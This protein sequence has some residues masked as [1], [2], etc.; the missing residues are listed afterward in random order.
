MLSVGVRQAVILLGTPPA[1]SGEGTQAMPTPLHAIGD[2]PFLDI[3]LDEIARYGVLKEVLLLADGRSKDA[4]DRYGSKGH[5][6]L[7]IAVVA[8]PD[9]AGTGDLLRNAVDHLDPR[10]LLFDGCGFFDI[11]LLD[12][13]KTAGD[14]LVHMALTTAIDTA[15][16]RR[17][18]LTLRDGAVTG[19]TDA[20]ADSGAADVGLYVVDRRALAGPA[21][22]GVSFARDGLPALAVQGGLSGR[23]YRNRFIDLSDPAALIK[24]QAKLPRRLA[25]PAV[26]FDRDGVLNRDTGYVF[27]PDDLVWMPGAREAVKAVNDAGWFAFV[28]SNQSGIARGYYTEDDVLLLHDWMASELAGHGAHIDAFEYCPDHPEGKVE[29]YRRENHDRKP[30]PGMLKK[31]MARFG[32]DSSRSFLVGDRESDLAAAAAAGIAGHLYKGGDLARF[33]EDRLGAEEALTAYK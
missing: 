26:F 21:G 28:V 32:V 4:V 16:D 22:N 29:P 23:L 6:R 19:F 27:R 31:L 33:V 2:R 30:G 10:F 24:A 15:G 25:R 11:N 8:A 14:S 13:V 17:G 5:D 3:L 9:A 7:R 1:R 18:R 12:L 20:A